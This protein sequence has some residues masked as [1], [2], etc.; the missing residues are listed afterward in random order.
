MV[1]SQ[2]EHL[3]DMVPHVRLLLF[4]GRVAAQVLAQVARAVGVANGDNELRVEY[5]LRGYQQM[6]FAAGG[7]QAL[8]LNPKRLYAAPAV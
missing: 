4:F 8:V 3:R 1:L 5:A 7:E 2:T 6:R